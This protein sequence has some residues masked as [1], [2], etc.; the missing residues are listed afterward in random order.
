[1]LIHILCLVFATNKKPL[2]HLG[3]EVATPSWYHPHSSHRASTGEPR[4]DASSSASTDRCDRCSAPLTVGL[5][6]IP[7]SYGE[8][9]GSLLMGPFGE[10]VSA[11]LHSPG[12]LLRTRSRVLFPIAADAL[13]RSEASIVITLGCCQGMPL[14]W[15]VAH[16]NYGSYYSLQGKAC[17]MCA[18]VRYV[19]EAPLIAKSCAWILDFALS[20]ED[21]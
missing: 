15:L 6:A 5:P 9:L 18:R 17:R 3:R 14:D 4:A 8:P 16:S 12:S 10:V 1:M 13:L 7:Y 2:I 21:Q 19:A 11:G 20:I